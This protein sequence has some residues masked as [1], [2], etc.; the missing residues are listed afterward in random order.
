MK[1]EFKTLIYDVMHQIAE[2][3]TF[4]EEDTF[5][6]V[7]FDIDLDEGGLHRDNN[8][9]IHYDGKVEAYFCERWEGSGYE[10]DV[11]EYVAANIEKFIGEEVPLSDLEESFISAM[12]YGAFIRNDSK[13]EAEAKQMAKAYLDRQ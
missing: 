6:D 13:H 4:R 12:E 2:N 7:F 8:V 3:I 11:E 10:D 5:L 9:T 1:E